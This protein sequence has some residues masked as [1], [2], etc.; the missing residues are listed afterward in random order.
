MSKMYYT[1][2]N[3]LTWKKLKTYK[4]KPVYSG[5]IAYEFI[6]GSVESPEGISDISMLIR[7]FVYDKLNSGEYK[8]DKEKSQYGKLVI[9]DRYGAEVPQMVEKFLY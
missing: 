8:I 3:F 7:K 2:R 4:L 5:D 6:I 9:V 1:N